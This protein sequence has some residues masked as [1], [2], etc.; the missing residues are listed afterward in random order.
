MAKAVTEQD[1]A[2]Y[3]HRKAHPEGAQVVGSIVGLIIGLLIC[4]ALAYLEAYQAVNK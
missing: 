1:I 2:E 4:K 3:V